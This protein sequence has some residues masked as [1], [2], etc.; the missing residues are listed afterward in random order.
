MRVKLCIALILPVSLLPFTTPAFLQA[1]ILKTATALAI[2]A[3]FKSVA[4][5]LGIERAT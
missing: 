2:T 3:S 1:A 5:A 4:K